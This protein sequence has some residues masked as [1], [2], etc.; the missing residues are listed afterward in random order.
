MIEHVVPGPE[1]PHFAKLYDI[2]MMC[3]GPGQERTAQEYAQLLEE[4]RWSYVGTR[5]VASGLMGL[6]EGIAPTP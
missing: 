2:H 6:I 3:W 4:A 5:P 1:T